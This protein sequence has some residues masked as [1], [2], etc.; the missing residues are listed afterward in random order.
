MMMTERN[1]VVTFKGNALTLVGPELKIGEK[2]PDFCV[3]ANDMSE[4]TMQQTSK[5]M[6]LL[7][8]VPSLDTP[9]CDMEVRRFNEEAAK[10]DNVEVIVISMDLPFAQSRWCGAQGIEAVK[11]VSDHRDGNFGMQYGVMVKELRLNARAIFVVDANDM[12]VYQEIVP[13]MTHEP[14]YEAAL[15]AISQQVAMV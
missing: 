2:A 15:K 7:I 1:N 4:M 9:V 13:E 11:T 14:N 12:L 10:M 5:K 6:R 3:I 8:S